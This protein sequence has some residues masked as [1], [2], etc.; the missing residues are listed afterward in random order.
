MTTM[1]PPEKKKIPAR[2]SAIFGC[3]WLL[4]KCL[5]E[6]R[7]KGVD[8]VETFSGSL[9]LPGV[10][11]AAGILADCGIGN[12]T[13]FGGSEKGRNFTFSLTPKGE[14]QIKKLGVFNQIV[15]TLPEFCLAAINKTAEDDDIS[16][17]DAVQKILDDFQTDLRQDALTPGYAPTGAYLKTLDGMYRAGTLKPSVPEEE[18]LDPMMLELEKEESTSSTAVQEGVAPVA[19]RT[20][21]PYN[22]KAKTHSVDPRAK[23]PYNKKAKA[24]SP[25]ITKSA[26]GVTSNPLFTV[27]KNAGVIHIHSFSASSISV[28]ED[29]SINI[30]AGGQKVRID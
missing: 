6:G 10:K 30:V 27:E 18:E 24:T 20:K 3:A 17:E 12:Y 19:P 4:A 13:N 29:G 26:A 5:A 9:T 1:A 21:R 16:P 23:R 15:S 25:E 14:E 11:N 8:V 7:V 2:H 28:Y 22:K